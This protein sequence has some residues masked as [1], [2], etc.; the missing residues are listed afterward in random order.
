MNKKAVL[1]ALLLSLFFPPSFAQLQ[2]PLV[3]EK[4]P[5]WYFGFSGGFHSNFMKYSNLDNNMFP[6]NK[7]LNGGIFSFFVERDF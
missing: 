7:N 2:G 5:K 3:K 6:D 1:T 4:T